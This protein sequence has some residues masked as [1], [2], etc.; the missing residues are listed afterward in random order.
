MAIW[1]VFCSKLKKKKR[2]TGIPAWEQTKKTTEMKPKNSKQW[3]WAFA[4]FVPFFGK[5]TS[6]LLWETD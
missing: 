5:N 2:N 1:V 6:F 4:S 3:L